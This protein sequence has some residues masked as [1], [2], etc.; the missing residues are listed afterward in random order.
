MTVVFG[1]LSGEGAR[2]GPQPV[3]P[4]SDPKAVG[5]GE[6]FVHYGGMIGFTTKRQE[7][8][9]DKI[10]VGFA[11]NMDTA[12]RAGVQISSELLKLATAVEG[13]R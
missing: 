13:V 12:R 4:D 8:T 9:S 1:A 5:D 11:I 6:Q 10:R 7:S 2:H 3:I